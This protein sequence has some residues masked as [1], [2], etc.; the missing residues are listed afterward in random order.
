MAVKVLRTKSATVYHNVTQQHI[1]RRVT[2]QSVGVQ[3]STGGK[4]WIGAIPAYAMPE[5]TICRIRT[6]FDGDLIIGT[7]AD[8]DAY[9]TSTDIDSQTTGTYVTDRVYGGYTTVDLPIYAVLTTAS[10]VG[11]AD[12]WVTYRLAEPSTD[13]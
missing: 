11:S 5:E 10:T 4:F 9:A 3:D 6:T 8:T 1:Y 12:V 13:A 7:S 2:W